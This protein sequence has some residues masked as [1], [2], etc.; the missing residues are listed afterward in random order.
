MDSR[1]VGYFVSFCLHSNTKD[2][3]SK[4]TILLLLSIKTQ[5]T[6]FKRLLSQTAGLGV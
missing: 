3:L 5:S 1:E 4:I 6:K 2:N